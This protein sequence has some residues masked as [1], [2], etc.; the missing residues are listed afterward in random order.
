MNRSPDYQRELRRY[1]LG[2]LLA[3][4]LTAL[5][6]VLVAWGGFSLSATLISVLALAVLQIL[7]HLYCFLQVGAKRSENDKLPLL[8]FSALIMALM[9]AGTLLLYFDQVQR[10]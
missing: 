10:M 8:G 9:I 2:L 6:T 5:P 4:T 1:R 3:I 7:A